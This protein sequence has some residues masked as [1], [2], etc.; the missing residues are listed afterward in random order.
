M[1]SFTIWHLRAGHTREYWAGEAKFDVTSYTFQDRI[2]ANL[3]DDLW[4]D[5]QEL[6]L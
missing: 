1:G 3:Y 4:I 5:F 6:K 2:K